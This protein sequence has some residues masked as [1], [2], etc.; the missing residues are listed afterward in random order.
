MQ[1]SQQLITNVRDDVS[2]EATLEVLR[3]LPFDLERRT[4]FLIELEGFPYRLTGGI[5]FV[6]GEGND[7]SGSTWGTSVYVSKSGVG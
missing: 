7:L 5:G 2:I 1:E 3:V 6:K 4:L